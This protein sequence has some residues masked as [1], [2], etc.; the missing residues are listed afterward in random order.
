M[1]PVY[2][3]IAKDIYQR[4]LQL[5]GELSV[6]QTVSCR[7]MHE[8]VQ[9]LVKET[10]PDDGSFENVILKRNGLCN[11]VMRRKFL[12]CAHTNANNA[13]AAL[14]DSVYDTGILQ[15]GP[16][17]SES[18]NDIVMK[19]YLI[20]HEKGSVEKEKAVALYT[21]QMADMANIEHVIQEI[22]Y[23]HK[24][25]INELEQLR[26]EIMHQIDA[27]IETYQSAVRL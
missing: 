19:I 18:I 4:L 7:M 20:D 10:I 5:R 24:T 15:A 2:Q 22:I 23:R 12:G 9:E 26:Q 14:A 1:Q 27:A 3:S 11:P 13:F 6:Y 8:Q 21:G 17:P 25:L 16:R